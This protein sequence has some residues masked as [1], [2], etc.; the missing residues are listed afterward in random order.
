MSKHYIAMSGSAGCL[1]DYC[2]VYPGTKEGLDGAVEG[3]ATLHELNRTQRAILRSGFFLRL[4]SGT[5]ADYA[6]IEQCNCSD[7]QIHSE[8]PLDLEEYEDA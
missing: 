7:P 5:G 8:H 6:Q 1:P 3:L 2:E 4:K